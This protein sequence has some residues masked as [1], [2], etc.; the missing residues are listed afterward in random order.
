MAPPSLDLLCFGL[1]THSEDN[2]YYWQCS[3]GKKKIKQ[4]REKLKVKSIVSEIDEYRQNWTSHVE[5]ME[6]FI[7][8]KAALHYEPR[9]RRDPGRPT[10][11]WADQ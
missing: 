5:R 10:K 9:G 8:P 6:N 1:V 2:T 4:I 11:R 7:F 3:Q